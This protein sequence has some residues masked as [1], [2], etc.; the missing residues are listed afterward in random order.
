MSL[1][2]IAT[3]DEWLAARTALLAREKEMTRARDA[4]NAERRRLPMV[5]VDKA[6]EFEGPSGRVGLLDLFEGRRQLIVKHFMYGPDWDVACPSCTAGT[7]EMSQGL[8]DHLHARDTT[9]VQVSRAPYEKLAAWAE[10]RGWAIPWYSSLG[11]DFN[12]DFDVTL[13]PEVKPPVYNYRS[14]P[15]GR[16]E[17]P[18]QSAFLRDGDRVFHTYS[19]YARGA[20][21]TGGSYYWL[22]MTALGRQEG[23]EEPKGRVEAPRDAT[24]DFA[25]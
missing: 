14:E 8:L 16:D 15:E 11:S 7:D 3:R 17:Q 4:L 24:P 2:E 9:L 12:Y 21:M 23:W 18:G 1:P 13:D 10:G 20:E 5:E 19:W 25:N 6:Y 22:D